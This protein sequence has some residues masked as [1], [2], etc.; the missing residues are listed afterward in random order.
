MGAAGSENLAASL[1]AETGA[2]AVATL[3][4]KLGGLIGTFHG[5]FSAVAAA[6]HTDYVRVP[7]ELMGTA[8]I[9][10]QQKRAPAIALG[11]SRPEGD[12]KFAVLMR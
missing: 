9:L 12:A 10:Q 6:A 2:E 1:G 3:A 5:S 7:I 8:P 11:A 4:D